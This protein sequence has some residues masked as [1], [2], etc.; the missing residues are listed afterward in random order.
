MLHRKSFQYTKTSFLEEGDTA[1]V[2]ITQR[3]PEFLDYLVPKGGVTLGA[4]V[5]VPVRSKIV[6]GVVWSIGQFSQTSYRKKEISK[7]VDLPSLTNDVRNFLQKSSEYNLLPLNMGLRLC[8]NPNLDLGKAYSNYIY[9]IGPEKFFRLTSQ[10]KRVL[11]F[12]SSQRKNP[13]S[14]SKLMIES[15]VSN[16]VI[17]DLEKK[18][19]ITKISVPINDNFLKIQA[20]FSTT[21]S[22]SQKRV[23]D[24][25]RSKVKSASYSTTMLKGVTGS[26]KT[27]VYMD[28]IAEAVLLGRQV[29]VL[30]PEISLATT[31]VERL[32]KRFKFG[33]AEWHSSISKKE[34][35]KI[36]KSVLDGSLKLVFGAR[37]AVFLPFRDLG[38][39]IVDEEHDSSYKQE[40]GVRYHGRD[41]AVLKGFYSEAA[42]IL[43]SATPSLETWVNV[44]EKKYEGKTLPERFG[45]ARLPKVSLVDLRANPLERN[46]WIS[47][48]IVERISRQIKRK[49]QSLLFLNRRG[50]TPVLVCES[51]FQTLKCRSCDAKLAEHKL[52]EALLCHLCGARY[53]SPKMCPSC[54]NQ[55]NYIPIGPGIEKIAEET[56]SLFPDARVELLSSDHYVSL[57]NLKECFKRITNG[58]IDIIIGTQL[59]SKGHNFPFLSFVG[60][61]DVDLAFNGGDFRAA[62]NTFQL[63]KQVIGRAGRFELP[64]EAC[65]QTYFPEDQVMKTICAAAADEK[66]MEAQKNLRE[67]ARVPP[68]GRMVAL[69]VS[70]SV[71]KVAMV[72]A[73]KLTKKI[74]PLQEYDVE[75]YGPADA[76][77]SKIR[78]KYRVRILLKAP[79]VVSIQ[80]LLRNILEKNP[81]PRAINLTIDVDPINFY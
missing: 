61:L 15:N 75:I 28:A 59:I 65:I 48:E 18:K 55:T 34:K 68:F 46:R 44:L 13:I 32:Q 78:K 39:V 36:L 69:I 17:R 37:S 40:E 1:T 54:G 14:K 20:T 63:L 29:L 16:S 73:K 62:E 3:G 58:E 7:I 38:L 43:V 74:L 71:H 42:V 50:Y 66:F 26:G 47:R 57:Q 67:M 10:R 52:F 11:D 6:L 35:N 60:I 22:K 51:C 5:H 33:F 23:S 81:P 25:L 70:S 21:L 24:D 76:R 8:L 12:L 79:K 30:F 77:I 2:V 56:R 27:E 9:E 53:Q 19:I 49:Q 4:I 80:P 64:G 45:N 72:F 41:M 31:F